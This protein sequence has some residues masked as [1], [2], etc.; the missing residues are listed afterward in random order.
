MKKQVPLLLGLFVGLFALAEF[1]LPWYRINTTQEHFL[2]WAQI[3]SA[4]AYALGG[5]NVLQVNLPKIRRRETD[6]GYKLIL[7]SGAIV[8][9]L[10]SVKWHTFGGT[11]P[12]GSNTAAAASGQSVVIKI[13][14]ANPDALA[15]VGDEVKPASGAEFVL[16]TGPVKATV[17]VYM[18]A[19]GYAEYTADVDLTQ[20]RVVEVQAD[21]YR[22]WG[23]AG[24][25]RISSWIYDH[26]F[27]PCNATMFALL[28]FFIASAA[29][30]A[31]RARNVEAALLLGAA[32][33]IMLGR[34]PIGRAMSDALPEI[35]DWILDIP[36]NAGRRAIM[37]GAALGAIAT[38]LR[39]ILGLERSHLGAD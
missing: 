37:M 39:V 24:T 36:N 25:G 2:D 11:A 21:T 32:I 8:M 38:G 20:P 29:F 13:A 34:A 16:P 4:A 17:K 31:F 22:Q 23:P 9:G 3:L 7:L 5:L 12:S 19:T 26:I 18:K 33:L 6:W 1:Y 28:A 14:S 10:C 27:A 30:R 35:S 15:K